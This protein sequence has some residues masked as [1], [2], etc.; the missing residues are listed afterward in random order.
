M[1]YT[2]HNN[3]DDNNNIIL[4]LLDSRF[5]K[6]LSFLWPFIL[7]NIN[8]FIYIYIYMLTHWREE[9]KKNVMLIMIIIVTGWRLSLLQHVCHSHRIWARTSN[10]LLCFIHFFFFHFELTKFL[11]HLFFCHEKITRERERKR[12]KMSYNQK[13]ISRERYDTIN[14]IIIVNTICP[15]DLLINMQMSYD[16]FCS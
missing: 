13:N 9:R 1:V 11:F 2:H 8:V 7:T 4:L 3:E 15:I 6:Y 12:N 16:L 10:G 14:I 5:D